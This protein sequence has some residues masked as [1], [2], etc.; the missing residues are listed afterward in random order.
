MTRFTHNGEITIAYEDLGGAG[1]DPLLLVM[2]LGTS[3]FWWPDG[4]VSELVDR[5]FHVA[6]YDQR[7][8]G[9]ST[10]LPDRRDGSP[11]GAMVHRG[12]PPYSAEDL[13]DDAVAALDAL[14][15][16][17]AH[18][19]GHSMGGLVAQRT[20]IRHPGRVLS[21]TSSSAVPSDAGGLRVLRYVRLGCLPRLARLHHP[22][23]P[24]GNLD[25]AVAVV[26]VL[27]A[28]GQHV[29]ERDV[30][31]FVD[32][33]AAH[34]ATG[35]RDTKA[36]S[37]QVGAKWHGGALAEIAAP[38]LVL[39][40][41]GDPL[42]RPSAARAIVDAVPGARL[43][44]LPGVGHFLTRDTW[45]TYAGEVRALADRAHEVDGAAHR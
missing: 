22:D 44:T 45:A 7:D 9:E 34:Q 6:A 16:E 19:F 31:E 29:D 40:G 10:H 33:D 18:V 1:G 3:R 2:G 20:A 14:G 23:T 26:R 30:R 41:E 17:R 25:L 32:K 43:R 37:R 27:A 35:L 36:Q 13:T 24:Q 39:H 8:A 21:L 5:G 28:P 38:T 11:I 15:W 12:A 42:I 4:L